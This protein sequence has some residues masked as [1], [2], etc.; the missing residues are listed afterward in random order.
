L[1]IQNNEFQR[2]KYLS[3]FQEI[4]GG[5][6]SVSN[7]VQSYLNLKST[8]SDLMQRIGAL[9]EEI[10]EYKIEL[11]NLIDSQ[12]PSTIN[13]GINRNIYRFTHARVIHND[14]FEPNNYILLN[15]GSKD[16]ITED[17]GVVSVRG[18]VGV[19][20][21]VTPNFSRVMPVLNPVYN[22]SCMIKNSRFF[23][24]LFWDGKDPRYIH[25]SRLASHASY[26]VG[27]TI[28][29]SGNSLTFPEGVFVGVVE[30]AFKRKNEEYISLKV[31][32]FTD[33]STLSE[34]FII[35]NPLREEQLIIEKGVN[36]E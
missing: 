3:V 11:E 8:N 23:G 20:T 29:T 16:G 9:E 15:K 6:Y 12:R 14:I 32:L 33:F 1:L 17:M 28:V 18:I 22:P 7:S 10:Q 27:D 4:A 19:V 21:K 24:P 36:V 31:R 35:R 25:L 30:D 13:V 34:V 2:S 26:V 5:V